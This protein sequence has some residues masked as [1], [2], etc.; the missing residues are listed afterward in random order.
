MPKL[1]Y[2]SFAISLFTPFL[3]Y[4]AS[5]PL[6]KHNYNNILNN[7]KD[8]Y[9]TAHLLVILQITP[10]RLKES[11]SNLKYHGNIVLNCR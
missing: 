10:V 7:I 8:Y 9:I 6:L 5:A 1:Y 4:L 3:L 2:L 11:N